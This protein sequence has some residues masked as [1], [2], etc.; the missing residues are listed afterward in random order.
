M[1]FSK[2]S[3]YAS[4]NRD[5]TWNVYREYYTLENWYAGEPTDGSQTLYAT[6]FPSMDAAYKYI[7]EELS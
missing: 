6:G 3:Y 5:G 2:R 1:T 7:N 4:E